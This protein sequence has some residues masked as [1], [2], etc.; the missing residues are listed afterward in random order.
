VSGKL[1]R[2]PTAKLQPRHRCPSE[3]R[4]A[5]TGGIPPY[6]AIYIKSTRTSAESA[7]LWATEPAGV[8]KPFERTG[9]GRFRAE[10]NSS[11]HSGA[12]RAAVEVSSRPLRLPG[13][14]GRLGRSA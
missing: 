8:R 5:F 7:V 3:G 9:D 10:S 13:D 2:F 12:S 6:A 4:P 14:R 1:N 11:W